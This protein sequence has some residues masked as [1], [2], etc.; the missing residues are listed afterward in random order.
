MT[1]IKKRILFITG[2]RADYGKLKPLMKAVE[3]SSAFELFIFVGGMHLIKI[4]GSTFDEVIK[5]NYKNVYV[6]N[7]LNHSG[8]MSVNLANTINFLGSHVKEIKPDLIVV[9]G[10]RV[11][12]LAGALVGAL[13]NIMVAHIEGGEVSGTI[14]ESIR[15]ATSKFAHLHFVSTK[16]A[17][18][19][20]LQMGEDE[21]YIFVIGSPDIDIM[22]SNQLP[23]LKQVKKRYEISFE[24]YGIL[25]YHPVTT[26]IKSIS[27]HVKA[28]VD[29]AIESQKQFVVIFPNNDPG[30]ELILKQ[31]HRLKGNPNFIIFPSMRFEYF[32]TL[33]KN[34][35]FMLGNSSAGVRESG[36]YGIPAIDVGSRQNGRYRL[37]ALK[38]IQHAPEDK[39]KILAAINNINKFHFVNTH[40]GKGKSTDKFI[41]II[42]QKKIWRKKLQ[43]KF[44]D[45][46]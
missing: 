35:D 10:D 4:L 31:Y 22:M 36:I 19:R 30:S 8:E 14:D 46:R 6:A 25:M 11:D 40:F 13:E 39:I 28:V 37:K 15:H 7:G 16:R 23:S 24:R 32:L 41:K 27:R 12:A 1:K 44:I 38:N 3:S 26:E 21:R 2:T 42:S 43:K 9:H 33:I 5:D 45:F 17:K 29:A 20:L 18:Q 34:A